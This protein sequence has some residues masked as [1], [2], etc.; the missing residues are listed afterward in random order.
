MP[1]CRLFVLAALGPA[2]WARPYH[3]LSLSRAQPPSWPRHRNQMSTWSIFKQLSPFIF[4]SPSMD[5]STRR[6]VGTGFAF[7]IAGKV[8]NVQIP[9]LFK[10]LIER[11]D[12]QTASGLASLAASAG[13]MGTLSMA[14]GTVL[15]GYSAARL[16]S[17]IFNELK[18]V[19]LSRVSQA[20]QRSIALSTFRQLH[21]LDHDFHSKS[22]TGSLTRTIDRGIKAV[23]V[24]FTATLFNIVPTLV[25]IGLVCGMLAYKF[26]TPYSLVALGTLGTYA[27]WTFAVTS[28][29]T[30]FRKAMNAAENDAS[31]VAL[32]SLL[33]QETVKLYNGIN[34]ECMQ[35][36]RSLRSYEQAAGK[37]ARTLAMLNIGQQ[38]VI[39]VGLAGIMG[40]TARSILLGTASIGDLVLVNGLLFQLSFPLN[41]LGSIYRELRQALVD[42]EAM[43]ALQRPSSN[44][45]LVAEDGEGAAAGSLPKVASLP[46]STR[47]VFDRVSFGY[48]DQERLPHSHG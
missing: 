30:Q 39:T 47:I 48:H 6:L 7:M 43:L 15:L 44:A 28:W 35:Y 5:I 37:T 17:N 41:F 9:V 23:N 22:S 21:R 25:E 14:G 45:G 32:D 46:A 8:A 12:G 26:G 3:R 13:V 1:Q 33:H 40:L 20:A 4:S 36:E 42:L 38:A 19:A 31:N 16:A 18:N 27:A 11:L 2:P 10:A 34:H 24:V 29:R